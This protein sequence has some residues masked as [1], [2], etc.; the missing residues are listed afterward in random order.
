MRALEKRDQPCNW[1]LRGTKFLLLVRKLA[2]FR[3]IQ[4]GLL[5]NKLPHH[6]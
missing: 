4:D 6:I 2:S 5:N 3:F 1:L